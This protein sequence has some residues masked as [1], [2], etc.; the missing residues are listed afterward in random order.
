MYQVEE[1]VYLKQKA[2]GKGFK[3]LFDVHCEG[4]YVGEYGIGLK[5]SRNQMEVHLMLDNALLY[6]HDWWYYY[7]KSIMG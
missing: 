2:G 7:P 6:T 4:V 1:E 5:S 3:F